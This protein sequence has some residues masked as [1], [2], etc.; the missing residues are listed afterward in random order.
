[1]LSILKELKI[2]NDKTLEIDVGADTDNINGGSA[3][4]FAETTGEGG[5]SF[6]GKGKDASTVTFAFLDQRRDPT[7]DESI[8]NYTGPTYLRNLTAVLDK[9]MAFG[10]STQTV[11]ENARIE[12]V[13]L[14]AWADAGNAN[15]LKPAFEHDGE[16]K[17]PVLEMH[18]SDI[19]YTYVY[20]PSNKDDA[21]D[22]H[23]YVH[24]DA[25]FEGSNTFSGSHPKFFLE[26][27]DDAEIDGTLTLTREDGAAF[28]KSR[29]IVYGNVKLHRTDAIQGIQDLAVGETLTF[30]GAEGLFNLDV[31]AAS[32]DS[33]HAPQYEFDKVL[34]TDQSRVTYGDQSIAV[35]ATEVTGESVLSAKAEN[36]HSQFGGALSIDSNS[37]VYLNGSNKFSVDKLALKGEGILIAHGASL[38]TEVSIGSLLD[39]S[40]F[41]GWLRLE[42]ASLSLGRDDASIL[43]DGEALTGLSAGGDSEIKLVPTNN[44]PIVLDKFGFARY[45]NASQNAGVLDLT[46][47]EFSQE[48]T[49]E[50]ALKVEEL[51]VNVAGL[52]KINAENIELPDNS[53]VSTVDASIIDYDSASEATGNLIIQADRIEADADN[54]HVELVGLDNEDAKEKIHPIYHGSENNGDPV[55]DGY[56]GY[57]AYLQD[58]QI[59]NKPAGLY[60]G[61]MLKRIDLLE[62][63]DA[64]AV[65]SDE[66]Q[67]KWIGVDINLAQAKDNRL[68]AQV[69]GIGRINVIANNDDLNDRRLHVTNVDNDFQ[70]LIDV[71]KDA[72]I[73]QTATNAL[74][75]F[76]QEYGHAATLR[77]GEEADYEIAWVDGLASEN[78]NYTQTLEKMAFTSGNVVTL[79]GNYL[80]LLRQTTFAQDVKLI[81]AS[82]TL[83]SSNQAIAELDSTIFLGEGATFESAQVL[84]DYSGRLTLG[85]VDW[86]GHSQVVVR[87][88]KTLTALRLESLDHSEQAEQSALFDLETN[89]HFSDQASGLSQF[90]NFYGTLGVGLLVDGTNQS[91]L[92]TNASD[93]PQ[94]TLD[95]S[96]LGLD[97]T[98]LAIGSGTLY[99]K[100]G[101]QAKSLFTGVSTNGQNALLAD[102]SANSTLRFGLDDLFAQDWSDTLTLSNQAVI[103]QGT[104]LTLDLMQ[105]SGDQGTPVGE[106]DTLSLLRYDGESAQQVLIQ[107]AQVEDE[108][109]VWADTNNQTKTFV[110][111]VKSDK[112]L[113]YALV[114]AGIV[115][116]D[117]DIAIDSRVKE[118]YA[119]EDDVVHF[120]RR[121][122]SV[123]TEEL[124]AKLSGPGN[125]Q[126][127]RG[128]LIV[129]GD[130]TETPNV[131][132]GFNTSAS[133]DSLTFA[134]DQIFTG[135]STWEG[136]VRTA[137]STDAA[138]VSITLQGA[139]ITAT[140]SA[141]VDFD[142]TLVLA[143]D[144][145]ENALFSYKWNA[146][147]DETGASKDLFDEEAAFAVT[148]SGHRISLEVSGEMTF[149]NSVT[150]VN[151]GS[152]SL[153]L[154]AAS[155]A[156]STTLTMSNDSNIDRTGLTE[157]VIGENATLSITSVVNDAARLDDTFGETWA[158]H[159]RVTNLSSGSAS[160]SNSK[161]TFRLDGVKAD[162]GRFEFDAWG[163]SSARTDESAAPLLFHI[164]DG[165][166]YTFSSEAVNIDLKID[167]GAVLHIANTTKEGS[168]T[169]GE[170]QTST[171]RVHAFDWDSALDLDLTQ[172]D[173]SGPQLH[174]DAVTIAENATLQLSTDAF[175]EAVATP[176]QSQSKLL[177]DDVALTWFV[178]SDEAVQYVE[179]VDGEGDLSLLTMKLNDS[180]ETTS[181]PTSIEAAIGDG[182]SDSEEAGKVIGTF[183][184]T[185]V[186]QAR[187]DKGEQ[188]G[189]GVSSKLIRA[190]FSDGG[191]IT[192]AGTE[193]TEKASDHWAAENSW[194]AVNLVSTGSGNGEIRVGNTV[195]LNLGVES[196]F[197][198]KVTLTEGSDL[199]IDGASFNGAAVYFAN[200]T[201]DVASKL[202][203]LSDQKLEL[204]GAKGGELQIGAAEVLGKTDSDSVEGI[205]LE[206]SGDGEIGTEEA[207][208]LSGESSSSLVLS[209]GVLFEVGHASS[210]L[211]TYEGTWQ[212][213]EHA[214]LVLND[215]AEGTTSLNRVQNAATHGARTD[216]AGN[217]ATL[218]LASGRYELSAGATWG[219]RFTGKISLGTSEDA[220]TSSIPTEEATATLALRGW[221]GVLRNELTGTTD[222]LLQIGKKDASDDSAG[223][224]L[225]HLTISS[226]N[227]KNFLGVWQV[228]D[229][230]RLT[231]EGAEVGGSI[232]LVENG[233]LE[234][235][236]DAYTQTLNFG[237]TVS[238]IDAASNAADTKDANSTTGSS[239]TTIL[240][241]AGRV[242][243]R[244][245]KKLEADRIAVNAGASLIVDDLEKVQ[246]SAV[247]VE[248]IFFLKTN[249]FDDS[250]PIEWLADNES[251][252]TGG[253]LVVNRIKLTNGTDADSAGERVF[254]IAANKDTVVSFGKDIDASDFS[255]KIRLV[256]GIIRHDQAHDDAAADNAFEKL[257]ETDSD[258]GLAVSG[259]AV[260]AITGN[261]TVDLKGG[262]SWESDIG[263]SHART[264]GD[265]VASP[266]AH[267]VATAGILDVTGYT[268]NEN[269]PALKTSSLTFNGGTALI[270]LDFD[271]W[272]N[273]IDVPQSATIE[274]G[275]F[276]SLLNLDDAGEGK[277]I[278][279]ADE[280]TGTGT[281][282]L[283]DET[284]AA[285]QTKPQEAEVQGG[286]AMGYWQY[287]AE[288]V[289]A[290]DAMQSEGSNAQADGQT[291]TKQGVKLGY[292]LTQLD[293][294]NSEANENAVVFSGEGAHNHDFKAW[295]TGNGKIDIK[296][297]T[298]L[299]HERNAFTGTVTVSAGKLTSGN[300]YTLSGAPSDARAADQLVNL[301]LNE[302]TAFEIGEENKTSFYE[303]LGSLTANENT[304]IN[305]HSGSL[306]L[307]NGSV[308]GSLFSASASLSGANDAELVVEGSTAFADAAHTLSAYDGD[309]VVLSGGIL[310]LNEA[311]DT[312]RFAAND[313]AASEDFFL[314][315][316]ISSAELNANSTE[317]AREEATNGFAFT[318]MAKL[319]RAEINLNTT[320]GKG[321]GF[322]GLYDVGAE[323][324][325]RLDKTSS[326][327]HADAENPASIHLGQ[328]AIFDASL[329][330]L[331]DTQTSRADGPALN[332]A[333][334][335]AEEKSTLR[336]GNVSIGNGFASAAINVTEEGQLDQDVVIEVT[337]NP[338]EIEADTLLELD[339]GKTAAL[340]VGDVQY[341][342]SNVRVEVTAEGESD[343]GNNFFNGEVVHSGQLMQD[344]KAIG[345]VGYTA[346]ISKPD[347]L[348]TDEKSSAEA[349]AVGLRFEAE[350]V[351][352][353]KGSVWQINALDMKGESASE[354]LSINVN[355]EESA[356]G[357]IE[358]SALPN[359]GTVA[360]TGSAWLEQLTVN[361]TATL[362]MKG[363]QMVLTAGDSKLG[364]SVID[365]QLAFDTPEIASGVE[366]LANAEP[367]L[368]VHGT[369]LRFTAAQ[370]KPAELVRLQSNG[371]L[372]F[373]DIQMPASDDDADRNIFQADRLETQAGGRVVFSNAEGVWSTN[374]V[375]ANTA[376]GY[377]TAGKTSAD[378]PDGLS[379]EVRD[380]SKIKLDAKN[381]F[382]G[383]SEVIIGNLVSTQDNA[384]TAASESIV[385][386]DS[387]NEIGIGKD[388]NVDMTISADGVYHNNVTITADHDEEVIKGWLHNVSGSGSIVIDAN[389]EPDADPDEYYFRLYQAGKSDF[390][391]TVAFQNINGFV[392]S[393]DT[394]DAHQNLAAQTKLEA[395]ENASLVVIGDDAEFAGIR[396]AHESA[397]L[398]L[399]KGFDHSTESFSVLQNGVVLD[400]EGNANDGYGKTV[401]FVTIKDGDDNVFSFTNGAKV[402]ITAEGVKINA[403]SINE[404]NTIK[405]GDS[406]VSLLKVNEGKYTQKFFQFLEGRYEGNA[407]DLNVVDENGNKL[408]DTIELRYDD[409]DGNQLVVFHGGI[410]VVGDETNT[411]S[412]KE[413]SDS[414]T[415]EDLWIGQSIQGMEIFQTVE[416]HADDANGRTDVKQWIQSAEGTETGI[417]ITYGTVGLTSAS[418]SLTGNA[419]VRSG[420]E[421][422]LLASNALGNDTSNTS[423]AKTLIVE[424]AQSD[425]AR[426]D[427]NQ[428]TAD[429]GRAVIGEEN[430]VNS[431][432]EVQV[433]AMAIAGE[434]EITE[435]NALA[436]TGGQG[437]EVSVVEGTLKMNEES[438]LALHAGVNLAF[439]SGA[440]Y[441]EARGQFV[442]AEDAAVILDVAAKNLAREQT[443][444]NAAK[445]SVDRTFNAS[446][447]SGGTLRKQGTGT[448]GV[449]ANQ[450]NENDRVSLVIESG[451]VKVDGWS[452]TAEAAA[453]SSEAPSAEGGNTSSTA[454]LK[455]KRLEVQKAASFTFFGNLDLDEGEGWRH[456]GHGYLSEDPSSGFVTRVLNGNY[457]GSNDD[458]AGIIHFNVAFGSD[459][460]S[461]GY[462]VGV[463]GDHLEI[464]GSATG[465]VLFDVN[466]VNGLSEGAAE[467]IMLVTVDGSVEGFDPALLN[468]TIEAGGYSYRLAST[469]SAAGLSKADDTA[470]VGA[471]GDDI[472]T[473]YFLTSIAGDE[474][475]PGTGDNTKPGN[476]TTMLS[477]N[478]GA[479]IG[480]AASQEMFDL[481]IHDR[482]GTQPYI[483]PFTGELLETSMWMRQTVSQTKSGTASGQLESK[484]T[485]QTTQIGGDL[486]RVD[487]GEG[488]L[489]FAGLM[490]GYGSMDWKTTSSLSIAKSR[491]DVDGWAGGVYLGWVENAQAL[492][493]DA[494]SARTGSYIDAWLQ[495]AELS[496][497]L[498]NAG[499][500]R[501]A[502]AQ[503]IV[504]SLEAGHNFE[505]FHFVSDDGASRGTVFFE[506]H[507][508]VVWHGLNYD[509][510][511]MKGRV[512]IKGEDN[513]TMRFGTRTSIE[514]EGSEGV[515]PFLDLAWVHNTKRY[516]ATYGSATDWQEGAKNQ[517]EAAFGIDGRFTKNLS[518]Y[519][520]FTLNK[521]DGFTRREGALGLRYVF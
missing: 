64:E 502:R 215:G 367:G 295:I 122:D 388:D 117:T 42:N 412:S 439:T 13:R 286:L 406:L 442:M 86:N 360:F 513:V 424:G 134:K 270:K 142:G 186:D 473:R 29:L 292:A 435:E 180:D 124:S 68:S 97:T 40:N 56:W 398:D 125:F 293:L 1:M 237:N 174:A 288:L 221:D 246:T 95:S 164:T 346:T 222:T 393:V 171:T 475:Q 187:S 351:T 60:L 91:K 44:E 313:S 352:L 146:L 282:A 431:P 364:E 247:E 505:A 14:G 69:T 100:Q 188:Y 87:G 515:V 10:R 126:L 35:K 450:F 109:L 451:T 443:S 272:K 486:V 8:N 226:G 147:Q 205:V 474:M 234:L 258:I 151:D 322:S 185:L 157:F 350:T 156:D 467:R 52:V 212:L 102:S 356:L 276:E 131:Y 269:A 353:N 432:I 444:D 387:T 225:S 426:S 265:L 38:D 140:R 479:F 488:G 375:L 20:D 321:E 203:V 266:S 516:G 15:L 169:E 330:G 347:A 76:S 216:V 399:T 115:S 421:L 500:S 160:T 51:I 224:T 386:V 395:W 193:D 7:S 512:N 227:A 12:V 240:A 509:A 466:D 438:A 477:P 175:I 283:V 189:V 208:K 53:E 487:D 47:F 250:H 255:G 401:N 331:T 210:T 303:R 291:D 2:E 182:E 370:E 316:R 127:D 391:G 495:Y 338:N 392:S 420:A 72:G 449:H 299:T 336:L 229:E 37:Y 428:Q 342:A 22:Q 80:T 63:Q 514:L 112:G 284:G 197:S 183:T 261:T 6:Q 507:A 251:V 58:S 74:G 339:D 96:R 93:R 85:A 455:L 41:S 285:I 430:G 489:W 478:L 113:S 194:N 294:R 190:E 482:H 162:A 359:G 382:S 334:L 378:E 163:T 243:A 433:H 143:N 460:A 252:A 11:L 457:I 153:Q 28:E 409:E 121:A 46:E 327:T 200:A 377:D 176:Q 357:G 468:G 366:T 50:P 199:A 361:E 232:S 218:S 326:W 49:L 340:I 228:E 244:Q 413:S 145:E 483:H 159:I 461:D 309:I 192:L 493:T 312:N 71:R 436:L 311:P 116:S 45:E 195:G 178:K 333:W 30:T 161:A 418:T 32:V 434:L 422:L 170:K 416:L 106:L 111:S 324:T 317:L 254:Q 281:F 304:A 257:F 315:Q 508:Q 152:A 54:I 27:Y 380:G 57:D 36:Y 329:Y 306:T 98:T 389:V 458:A 383:L 168:Q 66:E 494:R 417:D 369:T 105:Q 362:M 446:R 83:S 445:T 379:I 62:G 18:D 82:K 325:L 137:K 230:S 245:S 92:G 341:A 368:I 184:T 310:T 235:K 211:A 214:E 110:Y 118:V 485:L 301:V 302:K 447:I 3:Y 268:P 381:D 273:D 167:Q 204:H 319:A 103:A 264:E 267:P 34:I 503:G 277:W 496:A 128:P 397:V 499:Q 396:L 78:D 99:V 511:D 238:T 407:I 108:G 414:A 328:G 490:A 453:L 262:F 497:D 343:L 332:M 19:A 300:H 385:Y 365:G 287:T 207:F 481:S 158:E 308:D 9:R 323:K 410:G 196:N 201:D 296:T 344:R 179:T 88:D 259:Q 123:G 501:H 279:E 256:S 394:F 75:R 191:V 181:M 141:L 373:D 172:A 423:A 298:I 402:A 129:S 408:G 59:D 219:D 239:G 220:D 492:S 363:G 429:I 133:A 33:E 166:E 260:F 297:D 154:S 465:S 31:I 280:V 16:I 318:E 278:I 456:E 459:K 21:D 358:V 48:D 101:T 337:V 349:P 231:I 491:A 150:A 471:G 242:D 144:H 504:A 290:D 249:N 307:A 476:G 354:T 26:I 372:V 213:G 202:Q 223:E 67:E 348:S 198:G 17:N 403:E 371:T 90:K 335:H 448:L 25:L 165:G 120:S 520:S 43:T 419:T 209:E 519:A 275:S 345:T 472:V 480:F 314:L 23:L 139:S 404:A 521:G 390:N 498:S 415:K 289:K 236:G 94:V 274:E 464:T 119:G 65:W 271:Q 263:L 248:G 173:L 384:G 437:S 136:K 138:P 155:E 70:G 454:E 411:D 355:S 374:M 462:L 470:L 441:E 149:D 405:N 104:S 77:L 241:S 400:A 79:N 107:A 506:P 440:D 114:D 73:L 517:I 81:A 425:A 217:E 469:Q 4:W 427:T 452:Q 206:L 135:E 320:L 130:Q 518:G 148:G 253:S 39:L 132:G 305:L 55:A 463:S 484:G 5:L 510:F 84:N 233:I 376:D 24:G 89:A 61:Y 177:M